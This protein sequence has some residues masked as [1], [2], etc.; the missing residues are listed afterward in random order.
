MPVNPALVRLRQEDREFEAS[1]VYIARF[2]Q[3]K[4]KQNLE[5]Q[6][7]KLDLGQSHQYV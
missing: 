7:Q 1:L 6:T 2:S 5:K 4:T 3:N